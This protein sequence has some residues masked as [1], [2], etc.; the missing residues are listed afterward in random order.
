MDRNNY[1]R[2]YPRSPGAHLLDN[3][4]PI[5]YAEMVGLTER[6]MS[7]VYK[8]LELRKLPYADGPLVHARQT[9]QRPTFLAWAFENGLTLNANKSALA[10]HEEAERWHGIVPAAE[11]RRVAEV[12]Q[13]GE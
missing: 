5:G 4:G 7:S 11:I 3:E 8:W 9:W 1:T 13:G 6:S 2:S 12:E 10:S